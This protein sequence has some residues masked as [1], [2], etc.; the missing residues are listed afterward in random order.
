MKKKDPKTKAVPARSEQQE[1]QEPQER[2]PAEGPKAPA[3]VQAERDDLLDRLQRVSADYRNYQKRVQRDISQARAFAN[4]ELIKALLG[5]LDDMERALDAA[6]STRLATSRA[7]H[8]QDDPLQAGMQLVHDNA[9]R[10]LGKFGLTAIEA[11]GKPFDPDRHAAITQQVSDEHPPRTV[12]KELQRGYQLKGRTIRP[13][14]VIVSK[15]P[16]D[17]THA[18]GQARLPT[19]KPHDGGQAP[20]EHEENTPGTEANA[21][22]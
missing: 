5:V 17:E 21:R 11:E 15:E 6:R 16:D 19:L 1:Q 22:Q 4:E 8:S 20:A 2:A 18:G 9:L 3:D 7:N 13:A 10:T 12:L 14:G